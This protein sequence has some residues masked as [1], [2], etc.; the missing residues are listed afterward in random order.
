MVAETGDTAGAAGASGQLERNV[1]SVQIVAIGATHERSV[2]EL[3]L[4]RNAYGALESRRLRTT[5]RV[6]NT[7][8]L[9]QVVGIVRA[10]AALSM[11]GEEMRSWRATVI[12]LHTFFQR[13]SWAETWSHPEVL[14]RW[15][16]TWF[17]VLAADRPKYARQASAEL[18]SLTDLHLALAYV[19]R[20]LLPL[21]YARAPARQPPGTG[22]GRQIE[23]RLLPYVVPKKEGACRF[24]DLLTCSGE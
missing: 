2:G 18:P 22:T 8:F 20:L 21:A 17:S 6:I 11:Q 1:Q 5:D 9:P 15:S 16:H 23:R 12:N 7:F 14:M 4:L 3:L 24:G 10:C 19:Q 13:F